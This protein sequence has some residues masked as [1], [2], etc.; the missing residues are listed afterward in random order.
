MLPYVV[1]ELTAYDNVGEMTDPC[2][3][4]LL[5][6]LFGSVAHKARVG[7]MKIIIVFLDIVKAEEHSQVLMGEL[8]H[9]NTA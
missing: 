8:L 4:S 1:D 7:R 5:S 9:W 2:K 3:V 6:R